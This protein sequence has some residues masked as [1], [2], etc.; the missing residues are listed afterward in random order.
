L[1]FDR[2]RQLPHRPREPDQLVD[3][4]ALRPQRDQESRGLGRIDSV[5]HDLA[6]DV[7]GGVRA[8]VLPGRDRVDRLRHRLVRHQVRDSRKFRRI[9]LPLSVRTDSGWN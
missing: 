6:Q 2:E 5:A 1:D 9:S 3:G 7:L 4:L 8:Q